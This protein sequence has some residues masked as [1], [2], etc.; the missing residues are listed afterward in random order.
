MDFTLYFG[1]NGLFKPTVSKM[2]TTNKENKMN[3]PIELFLDMLKDTVVKPNPDGTCIRVMCNG[4][5]IDLPSKLG[6]RPTE[7][8]GMPVK[9]P[10]ISRVQFNLKTTDTRPVLDADGKP[11]TDE[12]GRVKRETFDVTP[13]L[14]TIVYFTDG[15]KCT[16][17]NSDADA[18]EVVDVKL[19]DG[20]TVKAASETSKER[21][22]VYAIVKRLLGKVGRTDKQ[23]KFHSNEID[24]NGF[25]RKLR[26]IVAGAYDEQVQA[27]KNRIAEAEAKRVREANQKPAKKRFSINDTLGRINEFLDR[28][29]N[30][31]VQA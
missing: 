12:K 11:V 27:A 25:G 6:A 19:S 23:G 31:E 29:E 16:V 9:F 28:A 3:D 13:V 14:A 4:R 10:G 17:V 22:V 8:K 2:N 20:T 1:E 7:F 21:A 24:G 30:K 15:T 26:D 18:V 5:P